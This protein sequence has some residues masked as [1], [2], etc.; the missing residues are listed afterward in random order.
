MVSSLFDR[1]HK[2]RNKAAMQ[3]CFMVNLSGHDWNTFTASRPR[4]F[5]LRENV[6]GR[7]QSY[8]SAKICI[9]KA[10]MR[11]MIT[12]IRRCLSRKDS[13]H[14]WRI[15]ITPKFVLTKLKNLRNVGYCPYKEICGKIRIRKFKGQGN[16][17]LNYGNEPLI[18]M[19]FRSSVF[20]IFESFEI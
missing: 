2:S 19:S 10:G 7:F 18:P 8:L 16:W 13:P 17:R 4:F 5:N 11:W 20:F 15:F 12:E 9:I 1:E 14:F 6:W 3:T